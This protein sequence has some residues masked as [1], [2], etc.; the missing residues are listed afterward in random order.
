MLYIVATPIGNLK[1]ITFRAI[2][3]LQSVDKIYCEDTR[4]TRKLLSAYSISKPIDSYHHHSAPHKLETILRELK[5]GTELAYVTD[6]GTPGIADPGG[7]LVEACRIEG[8]TVV[9]IPGASA[10]TTLL[11]VAGLP[12]NSYVFAGYVPTKKGRQTFIKRILATD[13]PVV[14]FET[15]PR[16]R[17][18]LSELETLGATERKIILGRE[19]T[20]QFEQIVSGTPREVSAELPTQV[21][22]ELVIVLAP[23]N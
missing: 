11:S 2:E 19:L 7:K 15:A 9:P 10:V 8:I 17:K 22:G 1:D 5:N 4:Q 12:A 14:L 13:E 16:I 23:A 21:K 20:K 18:L 3:T 6:A